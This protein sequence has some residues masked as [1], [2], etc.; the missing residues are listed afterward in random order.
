[1]SLLIAPRLLARIAC[2]G[3][4]MPPSPMRPP[5]APLQADPRPVPPPAPLRAAPAAV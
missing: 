4:E 2:A 5:I 1:M 3:L